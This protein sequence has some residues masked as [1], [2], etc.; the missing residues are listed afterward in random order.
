[1]RTSVN[2]LILTAVALQ[3]IL[4]GSLAFAQVEVDGHLALPLKRSMRGRYMIEG[5]VNGSDIGYLINSDD[6]ATLRSKNT[7]PAKKHA[8]KTE[9]PEKQV[10]G[11]TG[12]EKTLQGKK[13]GALFETGFG[14]TFRLVPAGKFLMG[15]KEGDRGFE[16]DETAHAATLTKPLLVA[17][18]EVTQKAFGEIM[19]QNPSKFKDP[20]NPVENVAWDQAMKHCARLTKQE[21][22]AGRLPK[23]LEYRLPTE[24]EWEYACRGGSAGRYAG[25][26]FEIGLLGR[27]PDGKPQSGFHER[28]LSS[29]F[30]GITVRFVWRRSIVQAPTTIEFMDTVR[31]VLGI[32]KAG[33]RT[34]TRRSKKQG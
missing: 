32:S 17:E 19:M 21:R 24:A 3:V 31:T 6:V 26:G 4:A 16:V 25:M 1:M 13:S 28:N 7:A 10:E 14:E 2:R 11:L 8:K 12:V 29:Q 15:T 33:A 23:G 22:A 30:G 27:H 20:D 5:K 34:K 9:S 18:R